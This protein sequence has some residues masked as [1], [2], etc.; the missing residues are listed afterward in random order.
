MRGRR[1]TGPGG[2]SSAGGSRTNRDTRP[3]GRGR[4]SDMHSN[5]RGKKEQIYWIEIEIYGTNKNRNIF[6]EWL[7]SEIASLCIR[8]WGKADELKSRVVPSSFGRVARGTPFG[9]WPSCLGSGSPAG[10]G[11]G[12]RRER[13]SRS[14]PS[15]TN[16][17]TP[18]PGHP[19]CSRTTWTKSGQAVMKRGS[20]DAMARLRVG[21]GVGVGV[22]EEGVTLQRVSLERCER[23]LHRRNITG[24][25][26]ALTSRPR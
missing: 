7:V 12:A 3:A 1:R 2:S 5:E 8:S 13:G 21:V 4:A 17:T 15:S 6:M 24:F 10:R 19:Q 25:S 14:G 18:R 20:H 9:R 11:A 22:R 26:I 16:R 23:R